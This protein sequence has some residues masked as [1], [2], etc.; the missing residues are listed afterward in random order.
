MLRYGK[1]LSVPF[2][3]GLSPGS[4]YVASESPENAVS[5]NVCLKIVEYVVQE[6][7][8]QYKSSQL[9]NID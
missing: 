1:T 9:Y 2:W 8:Y 6:K 5:N 4:E 3:Q 7:Y